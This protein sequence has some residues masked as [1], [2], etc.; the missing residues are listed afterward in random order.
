M[1]FVIGHATVAFQAL[2]FYSTLSIFT[3]LKVMLFWLILGIF[4]LAFSLT[5]FDFSL[6]LTL[7]ISYNLPNHL[8]RYSL[9]IC[10][11]DFATFPVYPLFSSYT[12]P[13]VE[14]FPQKLL[15]AFWDFIGQFEFHF[16]F[17]DALDLYFLTNLGFLEWRL[18][19]CSAAIWLCFQL[20]LIKLYTFHLSG[21]FW[22]SILC[23]MF[24]ICWITYYWLWILVFRERIYNERGYFS[25]YCLLLR[26][27][28][29]FF[30]VIFSS[31]N[32]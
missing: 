5:I 21:Y 13:R 11:R 23:I 4:P 27:S 2:L 12:V 15:F 9:S 29:S 24:T 8:L 7:E 18:K 31:L 14:F 16:K 19:I 6:L 26:I 20:R 32:S 10:F 28:F 17:Y 22:H 30:S 25:I 1:L 3:L